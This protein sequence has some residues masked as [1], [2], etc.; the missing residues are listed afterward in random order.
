MADEMLIRFC[1]PTLAGLKTGSLFTS[2]FE[3]REDMCR[4]IRKLNRSLTSKG[5]RV[6][7]LRYRNG[8]ALIYVYRPRHLAKDLQEKGTAS[9]LSRFGY[10]VTFP[11]RCVAE[12]M[13]R[14][15][16]Q[17][18]FPHEIGLFLGYPSEDVQGFIENRQDSKCVGT[19]RVYGDVDR[20]RAIFDRYHRCTR[21]YQEQYARGKTLERL[22][23]CC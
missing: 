9:M 12:L 4:D 15:Q 16:N 7:P 6:L 14:L 2:D 20:A 23:V 3:S 11:D 19:W 10:P 18:S 8:R 5:L 13:S 17:E 1:S 22:A 21:I